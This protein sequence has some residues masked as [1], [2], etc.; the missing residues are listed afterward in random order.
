MIVLATVLEVLF[1]FCVAIPISIFG[2]YGIVVVYY[3]RA[4]KYQG[5]KTWKLAGNL[6]ENESYEPTVSIVIPTHNEQSIITKKIDSLLALDY[7]KEKLE[8]IFADDSNDSTPNIITEFATKNPNIKLIKFKERIGYSPSMI[9]GCKSAKGEIIVLGDAGSFLDKEAIKHFIIHFQDPTVGAVTGRDVILNKEESVGDSE[10][11]Y[12]RIYNYLRT[13]ET[14]IDSTFFIKGEAT[15]A[16]RSLILDLVNCTATFDT[17]VGL[18][19]RQK[20]YRIVFD[21][22]VKFYEYAPST[23]AE[24]IKQKTIRASNLIRIIIQFRAIIFNRKYGKYGTIILPMYFAM[25]VIAP[26]A[27]LMGLLLLIPL[28]FL[29]T[30]FSLTILGIF[31]AAVCISLLLSRS[32]LIT[33]LDFEISLLK[34]LFGFLMNKKHDK[35]ETVAS[36]RRN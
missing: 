5:K 19:L 23:H 1:F 18:F 26:S 20:G 7:P 31:G 16:R 2:F 33:L 6:T 24:R 8:I 32:L 3:N 14:K 12:Q 11:L 22:Q 10:N 35:I 9:A 25:I 21:P 27:L 13:A 17:A 30:M 29:N 15:A 4:K 34:A 36:T 28:I